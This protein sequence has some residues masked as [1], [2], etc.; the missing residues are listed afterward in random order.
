[1]AN[2]PNGFTDTVIA[3]QDSNAHNLFEAGN[4][5]KIAGQ[6]QYLMLVEAIG[7]EGRRYFRSWT[8]S[9]INGTFRPLAASE[10]N[11]FARAN[12]VTFPGRQW[13]KD[14]SHGER[15]PALAARSPHPD[16]FHLLNGS[17]R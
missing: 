7:S 5:Y 11:P 9:S 8:S 6:N 4:S 12:N 15:L 13:T 1:M 17:R 16:E 10:S 3:M 14:V 2:F